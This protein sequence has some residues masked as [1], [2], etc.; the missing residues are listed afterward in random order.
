RAAPT[1]PRPARPR[2]GSPAPRRPAPRASCACSRAACGRILAA[3]PRRPPRVRRAAGLDHRSG[4][5]HANHGPRRASIEAPCLLFLPVDRVARDMRLP[6]FGPILAIVA[7]L[8]VAAPAARAQ[9][10]LAFEALGDL[11]SVRVDGTD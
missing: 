5:V 6:R 1:F 7:L 8:L 11:W 2:T 3:V 4:R 9:D 10:R